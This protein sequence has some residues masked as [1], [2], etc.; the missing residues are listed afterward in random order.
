MPGSGIEVVSKEEIFHKSIFRWFNLTFCYG[1]FD[2][3][4]S[5]PVDRFVL[6][7]GDSAGILFHDQ[8]K[9]EI[10]LVEQVRAATIG[11]GSGWILELPAGKVDHGEIPLK[12]PGG[13]RKTRLAPS[14]TRPPLLAAFSSR[15]ESRRKGF[16]CFTARFQTV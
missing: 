15:Q 3:T 1:R 9:D 12:R 5:G 10:I 11:V 13:R 8:L 2:G 14:P 7:W 6:D 16:T 4:K